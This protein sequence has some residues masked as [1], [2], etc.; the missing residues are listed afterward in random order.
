M[1]VDLFYCVRDMC[2]KHVL[3]FERGRQDSSTSCWF[4]LLLILKRIFFFVL[5]RLTVSRFPWKSLFKE[6]PNSIIQ[7][8]ILTGRL[9]QGLF[10]STSSVKF[11]VTE[12]TFRNCCY[13]SKLCRFMRCGVTSFPQPA[14]VV[15]KDVDKAEEWKQGTPSSP[16]RHHSSDT[17]LYLLTPSPSWHLVPIWTEITG[18]SVA[19]ISPVTWPSISKNCIAHFQVIWIGWGGLP[20][21]GA[22]GCFCLSS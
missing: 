3:L 22:G 7:R 14:S 4:F 18:T 8:C 5:R 21:S 12:I 16:L 20:R 13:G 17:L 15:R 2:L 6:V 19:S 10:H 11:Y 1:R 9:S